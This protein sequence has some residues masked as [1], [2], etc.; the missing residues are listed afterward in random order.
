MTL[1]SFKR[2][3]FKRNPL[4]SVSA[5]MRFHPILRIQT[6]TPAL[7]QEK[8]RSQFPGYA[9]VDPLAITIPPGIPEAIQA[10]VRANMVTS[11]N[12]SFER[13]HR[14]TSADEV[15]T[16]QIS[17]ES[18]TMSCK[19]YPRWE[20]FR[21]EFQSVLAAFVSIYSPP[22]AT[23]VGLRYQNAI[24]R[25]KLGLIGVPWS[26]L[27]NAFIAAEFACPGL[28][29]ADILSD[30]HRFEFREGNDKIIVQHGMA[31]NGLTNELVYSI[32]SNLNATGKVELS[33]VHDRLDQLNKHSGSLFRL[34]IT[35]QLYTSL[36]PEP[37]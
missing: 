15:W 21:D 14:F 31:T 18:V 17:Q 29:E 11:L 35:D 7:F 22:F 8:V 34:C 37:I 16:V 2:A 1:P 33:D 27:L 5:Q 13:V 26:S 4:F 9:M 36:E 28:S 6:E 23:M 32:D 3:V 19:E 25:S 10:A 30:L 12:L 24:E 20:R